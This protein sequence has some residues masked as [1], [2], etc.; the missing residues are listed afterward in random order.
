MKPRLKINGIGARSFSKTRPPP[1]FR[2]Y[3]Y[4]RPQLF[5]LERGQ[6]VKEVPK[7]CVGR[8]IFPPPLYLPAPL[9]SPRSLTKLLR[10]P[11]M[12][13]PSFHF[14]L[15]LPPEGGASISAT[16]IERRRRRRRGGNSSCLKSQF[17]SGHSKWLLRSGGNC[18]V[19]VSLSLSHDRPQG[20][21]SSSTRSVRPP[22]PPT[23]ASTTTTYLPCQTQR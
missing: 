4:T 3:R 2:Y 7:S 14:S 15:Y 16:G 10:Q 18:R 8:R 21:V 17:P 11:L 6:G 19:V 20:K 23:K 13:F 9:S 12:A 22:P 1:S 5:L